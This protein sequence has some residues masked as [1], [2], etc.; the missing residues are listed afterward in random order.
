M[1]DVNLEE[2][3]QEVFSGWDK[4]ERGVLD[5]SKITHRE[6]FNKHMNER[7]DSFPLELTMQKLHASTLTKKELE[8][9]NQD[10]SFVFNKV[11]KT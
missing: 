4:I 5:P 3:F 6:K 11:K 10:I 9:L 2:Y 1:V 7:L 8:K